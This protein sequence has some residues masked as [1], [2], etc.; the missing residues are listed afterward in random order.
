[1]NPT[2]LIMLVMMVGMMFFTSRQQRKQ[3]QN[4]QNQL[5][6]LKKGDEVVTIGGMYATVDEVDRDAKTIVLDVDGVYLTFELSAIKRVITPTAS[7]LTPV[8]A[9]GDDS[10]VE[11]VE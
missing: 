5:D 3:A 4:R 1:M 2:I 7:D 10:A 9:E 6:Q 8:V 11:E